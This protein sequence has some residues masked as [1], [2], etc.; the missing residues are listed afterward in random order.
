M[1]K[2]AMFFL[3][4]S[5]FV[6]MFGFSPNLYL[7]LKAG[8]WLQSN[9][10]QDPFLT[11][12]YGNSNF[13]VT[14]IRDDVTAQF[15]LGRDG[16][17]RIMRATL[18]FSGSSLTVGKTYIAGASGGSNQATDPS[19]S[20]DSPFPGVIF[21][22]RE[23]Q[24]S[25]ANK[26]GLTM[27]VL[28]PISAPDITTGTPKIVLAWELPVF[29]GVIFTP[30]FGYGRAWGDSLHT[31]CL[32][33]VSFKSDLV[34]GQFFLAGNPSDMGLVTIPDAD[35]VG[36]GWLQC[37]L[38]DLSFGTGYCQEMSSGDGKTAGTIFVNYK[39]TNNMVSFIPEVGYFYGDGF[40]SENTA[41]AGLKM[42]VAIE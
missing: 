31:T 12:L 39:L 17:V 32:G 41:Y 1:K 4:L 3:V 29:D 2:I 24:I 33:G 30:V 25:W 13:G 34:Q 15:E 40:I 21:M 5:L 6:S 11:T 22:N 9:T 42:V 35:D 20:F 36:G 14:F 18:L 28:G 26:G 16:G 19:F 8:I 7:N 37:R 38:G 23:H 27:T 10:D